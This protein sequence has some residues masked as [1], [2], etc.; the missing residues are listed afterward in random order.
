[1][2][3]SVPDLDKMRIEFPDVYQSLHDKCDH[4]LKSYLIK[5]KKEEKVCIKESK[6]IDAKFALFFMKHSDTEE[7]DTDYKK[8]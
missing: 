6:K 1:M 4:L 8:V 2:T 3:L 5:K 7:D